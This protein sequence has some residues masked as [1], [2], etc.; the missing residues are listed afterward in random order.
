[1]NPWRAM[2]LVALLT[3]AGALA[4]CAGH[5]PVTLANDTGR[6]LTLA[7]SIP[8]RPLLG[9]PRP[10][11]RYWVFLKPGAEWTTSRDD[12]LSP[13]LARSGHAHVFYAEPRL[14]VGVE[15]E[16]C[17]V[18]LDRPVPRRVSIRANAANIEVYADQQG[19]FATEPSTYDQARWHMADAPD[20][21][22]GSAG[23]QGI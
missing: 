7:V 11:S 19:P 8:N 3:L 10:N 4:A 5:S 23:K 1:M 2:S 9:Y 22:A 12:D 18:K 15:G 17:S 20:A 6:P 21:N 16:W 13:G 14:H